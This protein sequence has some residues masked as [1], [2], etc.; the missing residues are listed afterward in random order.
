MAPEETGKFNQER[1]LSPPKIAR[2]VHERP[3]QK[4][5][6]RSVIPTRARDVEVSE[7]R[8]L[9]PL[10]EAAQI[11]H[12]LLDSDAMALIEVLQRA[13]HEAYFV[14]GC[15]RDLLLGLKPKD[16]DLATSAKPNEIKRLF[17]NCRLIGRRF[18]LAHLLYG[19]GKIIEVA[20]FRRAPKEEFQDGVLIVDDNNF[21]DRL[22][23]AYRRD[24]T[25][26]ALFYDPIQ[27]C[28]FDECGGL[29]DLHERRLKLIGE[30]RQ[31]FQED[32]IRMLRGL[33]FLARLKLNFDP[34]TEA[35]LRSEGGELIKA[36]KPRF[37]QELLRMLQGGAAKHSYQLLE[38][39]GFLQILCPELL[40]CW[41][42][43]PARRG[44]S[45]AIFERLDLL[46]GNQRERL[47]SEILIAALF[48]PLFDALSSAYDFPYPVRA[49]LVQRLLAPFA[50]RVS[51]PGKD[52]LRASTLLAALRDLEEEHPLEL[53][54]PEL[55]D[56]MTLA[57]LCG[58]E[59]KL[60]LERRPLA[61]KRRKRRR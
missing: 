46:S 4:R 47:S 2:G 42:H 10:T 15:V 28:I 51:F 33:K 50:E 25:I 5:H 6:R 55:E 34:T 11:D 24:F 39:F 52:L 21:G 27:R 20:T 17:R 60:S 37:L 35:A 31:R 59:V 22:S 43:A 19:R 54:P 7:R 61:R 23:D 8:E 45:E 9:A 40:A 49:R 1:E 13:G 26:N 58:V 18:K 44:E 41:H 12:R 14:G 3:T 56:A 30:P 53:S 36:A 16:F 38:E 32:P 57:T 29:K 48:W